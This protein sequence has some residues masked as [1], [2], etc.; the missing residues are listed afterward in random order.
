M[1]KLVVNHPDIF[2]APGYAQG[3][4]DAA[5][6][7][8]IKG[9][10]VNGLADALGKDNPNFV[11]DLFTQ[12]D[13]KDG[14]HNSVH[15]D[16]LRNLLQS[17]QYPTAGQFVKQK[18]PE[19]FGGNSAATQQADRDFENRSGSDPYVDISNMMKR[20]HDPA[21][22]AELINR[23]KQD[24][25]L[26]IWAQQM[27]TNYNYNG[28]PEAAQEAIRNAQAQGVLSPADAQKYLQQ[29]GG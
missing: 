17:G 23:M 4:I 10:D 7:N 11:S 1:Q 8:G 13:S 26:Q 3:F 6:A 24:G 16:Q 28:W 14:I 19:L 15:D 25:T 21:Y 9:D 5:K 20:N 29:T 27:G 18:S 2:G 22:Q 12:L